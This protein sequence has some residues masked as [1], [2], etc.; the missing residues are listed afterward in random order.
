MI[1]LDGRAALSA[2]AP[3][4]TSFAPDPDMPKTSFMTV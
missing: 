2:R 3:I 1:F 4:P